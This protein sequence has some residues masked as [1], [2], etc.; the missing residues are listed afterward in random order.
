V[1]PP[2]TFTQS[3]QGLS[4]PLLQAGARSLVATGWRISDRG[5]LKF[6]DA[7]Y[8]NM[9]RGESVGQA[10]RETKL[11]MI[12]NGLPAGEWA[13][14]TLIGDPTIRIPLRPPR[15]NTLYWLPAA[16]VL[17]TAIVYGVRRK[18]RE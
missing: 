11:Q 4:G 2:F 7:F 3:V 8:A 16:A 13:G 5:T 18:R 1:G 12:H 14:F 17:M 9:A 10:L 15:M 6:V